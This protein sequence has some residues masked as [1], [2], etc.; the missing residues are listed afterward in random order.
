VA[1]RR[2]SLSIQVVVTMKFAAASIIALLAQGAA[3]FVVQG[4]APIKTALQV[5]LD[6]DFLGN[7]NKSGPSTVSDV[8]ST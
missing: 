7:L 4:P 6:N 3:G 2:R 8:S 1:T 5:G